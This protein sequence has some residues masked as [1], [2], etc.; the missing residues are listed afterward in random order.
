MSASTPIARS[1]TAA[2]TRV[3]DL[4]P[5]GYTRFIQGFIPT[6]KTQHLA[7]KFHTKFGIGCTPAQRITR[8]K[9]GIANTALVLYAPEGC[10]T[11]EWVL[12]ATDG[13]CPEDE[14]LQLVT[15]RR[16]RMSFLGY[17]L[18]RRSHRGRVAW[19]WKRPRK[20]QAD[21][22]EQLYELA[23]TSRSLSDW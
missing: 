13:T 10:T 7:D 14:S 5:R 16:H 23:Q 15:D 11:V 2:L 8:K 12:L 21:L 6:E 19:T 22:Y 4:V 20:V 17:E 9:K 1:K 3:L 18:V